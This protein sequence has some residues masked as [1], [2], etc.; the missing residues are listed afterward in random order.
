MRWICDAKAVDE[1]LDQWVDQCASYCVLLNRGYRRNDPVEY[2]LLTNANETRLYAWNSDEPL[3]SARFG[4]FADRNS[5]YELLRTLLAPSA[6]GATTL[7]VESSFTLS[8]RSISEINADFAW[9]HRYIWRKENLSY[10]AAFMEF[11]KLVFLKLMSDQSLHEQFSVGSQD[12]LVVPLKQVT[13]SKAWIEDR[14]DDTPNPLDAIQFQ[15]LLSDFERKIV[16]GKKK[17]IFDRGE[18]L[19]LTPETIKAIVGRLEGADLYS[20]DADLNGRLFETF[21]NATLRGKDLGQYFTPRSVVKLATRLARI[22][23]R[24]DH[25]DLVV[26]ACCGTGGFLIETLTDME[27]KAKANRSLSSDQLASLRKL[28]A[29][30]RIFGV[31]VSREP[32]LA[33]IAR[34][35]MYLHGDGGSSVFQVDALDKALADSPTDSPEITRERAELREIVAEPTGWAD[36]AL[37]NPPFAKEY[38]R[39]H[40]SEKDLLDSYE[41]G[42]DTKG[43]KRKPLKTQKSSVLFLERYLGLLR[44]GGRLVT[45]ID[46]S[47]LGADS[48]RVLRQWLRSKF[49]VKA[50]VSLPGDAFQRSQARV[51]T[52]VIV[53]ERKRDNT[54]V[55]GDVFM[56]YCTNVGV[57]DA[58]RQR[59]LP[60]DEINRAEAAKETELVSSLYDSFLNGDPEAEAWIVPAAAIVE[61]MDVKACL[62]KPNR[63]VA[64]WTDMGYEV[65]GLDHFVDL[66]VTENTAVEGFPVEDI[67]ER[68]GPDELV[69][70]LKVTYSGRAERGESVNVS[71]SSQP[72]LYRVRAGQVVVSHINAVHGAV[73]VVPESLDGCVVSSEYGGRRERWV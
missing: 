58:P 3:L 30:E 29:E 13:F 48:Y 50:V 61:R 20:I 33:R 72:R 59:V 71:D 19:N 25:V 16:D 9:C 36:V 44:P 40:S 57:D 6:F 43:G 22:E 55:Q 15:R 11:V 2:F 45:V 18:S 65:V 41:L 32:A 8:A 46:D 1:S 49:L 7:P 64:R 38:S 26:D 27:A 73:A 68:S 52:S 66:L 31:D 37:T 35:N 10:S 62:T 51:K 24:Q 23:V 60:I 34:I 39:K 28:I 17:R 63:M 53:L 54:D 47:I 5:K 67:V 56:Y 70:H 42:F 4:D 12:E 69:V 14:E 21:L